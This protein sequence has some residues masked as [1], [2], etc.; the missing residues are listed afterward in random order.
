MFGGDRHLISLGIFRSISPS[1]PFN[2]SLS[3]ANRCY[4]RN[5]LA[6]IHRGRIFLYTASTRHRQ[7]R[8]IT[9]PCGSW[10]DKARLFNVSLFF[11]FLSF[12]SFSFLEAIPVSPLR[13]RR[14]ALSVNCIRELSARGRFS[15]KKTTEH[16]KLMLFVNTRPAG[17]AAVCNYNS[18]SP[19]MRQCRHDILRWDNNADRN[20]DKRERVARRGSHSRFLFP[21][22]HR[23]DRRLILLYVS[24]RWL[25]H[26]VGEAPVENRNVYTRSQCT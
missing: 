14:I 18:S 15:D 21:P 8:N 13:R 9:H 5:P 1:R 4:Q 20:E 11:S 12:F 6:H 16:S 3:P 10:P 17:T 24:D 22:V 2:P 26:L 23:N 25:K 7:A 19:G